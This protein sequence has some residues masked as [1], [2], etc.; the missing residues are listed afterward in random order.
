MISKEIT[1]SN[2]ELDQFRTETPGTRHVHFN[3]AGA[4]LPPDVVIETVTNY[5][6]DEA[7][8][9]AYETERKY[10][11]QI[12]HVYELIAKLIGAD[13]DEVAIFENAGKHGAPLSKDCSSNP[14]MRSL[15]V[16]WNT[17]LT[18]LT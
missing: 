2:G 1:I 13:K 14:V 17:S 6:K 9:G 15:P 4:S 10:T 8:F 7:L 18:S 5:F 11:D 3:D 12:D 16:N